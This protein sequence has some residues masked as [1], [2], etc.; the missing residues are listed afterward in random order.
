LSFAFARLWHVFNMREPGSDWLRNPIVRSPYTWGALAAG[1]ALLIAALYVPIV[2]QALN[3]VEPGP[4]GWLLVAVGSLVPL[5]VGQ[6][7][8]GR[9]WRGLPSSQSHPAR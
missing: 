1:V 5:L 9:L 2:A 4:T 8:K 7:L 6:A 3:T